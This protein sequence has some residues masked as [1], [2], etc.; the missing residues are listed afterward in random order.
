VAKNLV[1]RADA[2]TEIGT[3]HVMRCLALAQA[4]QD[5]GGSVIFLTATRIPALEKRLKSEDMSVAYLAAVPGSID[6]ALEVANL[7]HD[8]GAA[9]IVADGYHF[10]ADYQ[11]KLKE[12]GARL[13]QI[14][15]YGH[16][17]HYY[18][19]IVL[20]QNIYASEE[21]YKNRE[22]YTKLL[23]GTRYVLLRREFLKWRYWKREIPD[24][25]RK[26]LVTLG[27]SD[28]GNIALKVIDSI[29][30]LSHSDLE[31]KIIAGP[32]NPHEASLAEAVHRSPFTVHRSVENIP[33]FMAWADV[34]ISAAGSTCWELAF[35]GVPSLV[36]VLAENQRAVA[37]ELD[38]VGMAI[39][40]GWFHEVS[41]NSVAE[42][43]SSLVH[44]GERRRRMSRTGTLL[45]DGAGADRVTQTML[46]RHDEGD[47]V[48]RLHVRSATMR[49]AVALWQLANDPV[50]RRNSF[51]PDPIPFDS[52]LRWFEQRLSR[53]D[54]RIYV[55]E[56]DGTA[57]A[58]VRYDRID[59][60]RAEIDFA[61][62]SAYRGRGIGTRA[63]SL[64]C[65]SAQNELAVENL[66]GVVLQ[67]NLPSARAF[68]KA[69]FKKMATGKEV[70]GQ[71][72][73]LFEWS[74]NGGT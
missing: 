35:M 34:A 3:G 30:M 32:S 19:D 22:P 41:E 71:R 62:A 68:L 64:T 45:V 16:A 51:S 13:L 12:L 33:E 46:A 73:S 69:G 37:E 60:K 21:I 38:E 39:S 36:F 17:D 52:H 74:S 67:S 44:A 49:D 63:L 28:P 54:T 48:D 59:S 72:C 66:V 4:W 11:Q 31:V 23:L 27:G 26:I 56:L 50:M 70:R 6:D 24:V 5:A 18:A 61:V 10:G 40:L 1:I 42:V 9:W 57:V 25:A 53:P 29:K 14:D 58:Q 20:N 8:F 43:L 15:D 7:S 65:Q 55:L 2:G 47:D